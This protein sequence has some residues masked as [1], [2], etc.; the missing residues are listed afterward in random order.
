M[1]GPTLGL[2]ALKL[3]SSLGTPWAL[4]LEGGLR[5]PLNLNL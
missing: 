4:G 2:V 5:K 1:E 3:L